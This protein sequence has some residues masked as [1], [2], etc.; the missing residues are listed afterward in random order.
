MSQ[1]DW[2]ARGFDG[3]VLGYLLLQ[4][5][6]YHC[7]HRASADVDALIQL[8]RTRDGAGRTALAEMRERGGKHS[9]IVS[10]VGAD[11]S[12]KDRLR[13]RGYRWDPAHD[14]RVWWREVADEDLET[15]K[16]WLAAHVYAVDANP[17]ALGPDIRRIT[18]RER[19]L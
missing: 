4:A 14:R 7:G 8:L 6:H 13:A 16:W 15:E 3:K 2:R 9:W 5:G 11:F 12:V 17:K 10:A 1:I 18:A 19:F